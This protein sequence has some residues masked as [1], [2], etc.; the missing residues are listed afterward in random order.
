MSKNNI[1][2]ISVKK[3]Y[4]VDTISVWINGKEYRLRPKTLMEV[5]NQFSFEVEPPNGRTSYPY[6]INPKYIGE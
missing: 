5:L 4:G 6:L 2:K 3:N 1:E